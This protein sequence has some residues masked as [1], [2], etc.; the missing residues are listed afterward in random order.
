MFLCL[1]RMVPCHPKCPDL[2]EITGFAALC[3]SNHGWHHPTVLLAPHHHARN[4]PFDWYRAVGGV[5][6]GASGHTLIGGMVG[7]VCHLCRVLLDGPP[8]VR[9]VPVGVV[10]D[11][12]TRERLWPCQEN[13]T[14]PC[15]R[16]H[17]RG[18]TSEGFP[19]GVRDH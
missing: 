2:G 3:G 7:V 11:L 14:R 15:E 19:H 5:D 10:D 4:D 12:Q 1:D 13:C 6:E 17:V 9:D 8:A 16:L 18:H